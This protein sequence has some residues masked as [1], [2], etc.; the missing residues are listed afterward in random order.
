MAA[1]RPNVLVI[2]TDEERYPPPYESAAVTE[3]RR[4]QLPARERLRRRSRELHRHCVGA[5]ACLPS[6]ATLFTGQYP[7]LHGVTNTD[8]L[9]KWET[10]HGVAPALAPEPA[11]DEWE[12]YDLTADPEE[13]ANL[14]SAAPDVVRELQ[15]VL[16]EARERARRTPSLAALT[17]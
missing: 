14:A 1:R 7:S 17:T 12:V 8:G 9:A 15:A 2:M 13:R 16:E 10:A 4:T 3:F 11:D 5:T 6:R